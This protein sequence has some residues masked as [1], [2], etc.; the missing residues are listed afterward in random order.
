MSQIVQSILGEAE[1]NN[2]KKVSKIILEVGELTF[3]GE[4][5]LKFCFDVLS[6]GNILEE[7]EFVIKSIK[8]EIKCNA[9]GFSGDLEYQESEEMHF[10]LPKFTCPKCDSK[11]EIIK[12]KDCILR[13][14]SGEQ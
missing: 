6:K 10:R 13:E 12:G 14:I 1:K 5:Q 4:E 2:L 3:L 9:C 11:I 8:P 7:A